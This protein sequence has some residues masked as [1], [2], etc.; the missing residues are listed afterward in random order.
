MSYLDRRNSWLASPSLGEDDKRIIRDMDERETYEAFYRTLEFGTGGMR[1]IMDLGTNRMNVYTIRLA[2][3]AMGM[4]LQAKSTKA[5][6]SLGVF[7]I[8]HREKSK[9][10]DQI[11]VVIAYDTRNNSRTYAEE[12]AKVLAACGIRAYLFDRPSPVPLLSFAVRELGAH[13]GV[14]ITASHNTKEYN[15]FKVYDSTGC[16]ILPEEASIIASNMEGIE[17][18]LDVET[19]KMDD[20]IID[21]GLI[22]P[23]GDDIVNRFQNAISGC[24]KIDDECALESD[25]KVVYT[26]LH[27]SGR[28]YVMEALRRGG[29]TNVELVKAQEDFDGNFPT[30][31]K[32]N[33]EDAAAL[34]IAIEQAIET[35]ADI[36]IG[37]DPDCDRIGVAIVDRGEECSE[38]RAICLT[39]N[40]TG[41]L[42]IDYLCNIEKEN[43]SGKPDNR[44]KLITTIV[45]GT[46]GPLVARRHG[47]EVETVLTGFKY[48]GDIMNSMERSSW[49]EKFLMG[50]EE[51]YG[52]LVGTHA[53]DKD[54]VGT[55]LA[56]CRMADYYR[57]QG[58]SLLDRLNEIYEDFGYW[59]DCQESFE[60]EGSEGIGTMS[61]I[62][63]DFRRRG[64]TLFDDLEDENEGN[65]AFCDYL[66]EDG[67]LPRSNVLKYSLLDG[68]WMA[69]RPSGTEPKIKIYYCVGGKDLSAAMKRQTRIASQVHSL[70]DKYR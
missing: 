60:F 28:D 38:Q 29:F 36:V 16:Q 59:L 47:L 49:R 30:V 51:S 56:I 23:I 17:N 41:V 9:H 10:G 18:P 54:G 69:I 61:S 15:G 57:A 63:A 22:V 48:I 39:G 44:Y 21:A 53:R 50:Y 6:E 66:K 3:K 8:K 46:L 25:L 5:M 7:G 14:V 68:S 13:G 52:Y 34:Q 2:A 55:A 4:M 37:T 70:V 64:E 27:G 67:E 33:P 62:M 65:I 45:T 43:A 42:L 32:P 26:S 24:G 20:A 11:K 40:Q 12:T 35:E 31:E 58:K 19:M 1:G